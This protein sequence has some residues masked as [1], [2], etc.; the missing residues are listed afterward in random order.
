MDF[1]TTICA[2]ATPAYTGALAVVRISGPQALTVAG[3]VFRS[4][5]CPDLTQAK[6]FTL[7]YGEI[8]RSQDGTD[9]EEI[10]DQVVVSVFRAPHSFTGEDSVEISCHGS[11]YIQNALVQLLIDN[12]AVMAGPGEFSQRA[13]LNGKMDLTQVEAVADVIASRNAGAHRLALSQLRGGFSKELSQLREQ[14]VE[15]ASLMELELDF[16]DQDVEFADRTRLRTLLE[17][18]RNRMTTLCDSFRAGNA[19]KNGVPVAIVGCVNAGKSTL[20][21]AL[22]GQ[23]R[24]IVSAVPGTTRDT[25]EDSLNIE[26][27]AF[28]FADTAGLR[29]IENAAAGTQEQ[30][31]QLGVERSLKTL[32]EAALVVLVVDLTRPETFAPS[33]ELVKDINNSIITLVLNKIDA[34]SNVDVIHTNKDVT[35]M[36]NSLNCIEISASKHLGIDLLKNTL[37]QTFLKCYAQDGGVL[38]SLLLN[39]TRHYQELRAALDALGHLQEGMEAQLP[40]D[41]LTPDLR[42]VLY[43]I[44]CITGEIGTEEVLGGIFSKFCIGK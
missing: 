14:L 18:L 9:R 7:Y 41:L 36:R 17:C 33:I 39:N 32:H 34:V 22:V 3:R 2:L 40:T 16:S 26:G 1:T 24:A 11:L 20:L 28:R 27:I 44:G 21:N 10:L 6:G 15:L 37:H 38:P 31:E 13:F 4:R 43:H 5:Q 12:G 30:I 23:E 8:V 25:I 42:Q 35:Y 19:V 29:K